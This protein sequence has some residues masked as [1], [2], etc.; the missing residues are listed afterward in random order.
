MIKLNLRKCNDSQQSSWG[1]K[2]SISV[3]NCES[4]ARLS[5]HIQVSDHQAVLIVP[6]GHR[7]NAILMPKPLPLR[8]AFW[9]Q[10]KLPGQVANPA[11]RGD[12]PA[13]HFAYGLLERA[14]RVRNGGR[15]EGGGVVGGSTSR[16]K[17]ERAAMAS[18]TGMAMSPAPVPER[19][20]PPERR[21]GGRRRG[22]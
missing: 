21:R 1:T 12:A 16:E 4:L 6:L 17:V 3:G 13:P 5:T 11:A 18:S 10:G 20:R 2:L 22:Q 19:P 14:D 9:T 15:E 7:A 8:R